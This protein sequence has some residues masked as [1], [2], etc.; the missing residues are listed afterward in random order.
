MQKVFEC[1]RVASLANYR[2]NFCSLADEICLDPSDA[3]LEIALNAKKPPRFV[4]RLDIKK[5]PET[6]VLINGTDSTS[7]KL[8]FS[9][10]V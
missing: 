8:R 10:L 2:S 4:L 9:R 1:M 6:A 7:K 3:P 5:P